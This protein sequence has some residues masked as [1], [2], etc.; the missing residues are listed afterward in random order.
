MTDNNSDPDRPGSPVDE[1]ELHRNDEADDLRAEAQWY[2][3][4]ATDDARRVQEQHDRIVELLRADVASESVEEHLRRRLAA[5]A[6]LVR[7]AHTDVGTL[8]TRLDTLLEELGAERTRQLSSDPT[9]ESLSR[10]VTDNFVH[11]IGLVV[12][13]RPDTVAELDDMSHYLDAIA[14]TLDTETLRTTAKAV[15]AAASEFDDPGAVSEVLEEMI[16]YP[17]DVVQAWS[18]GAVGRVAAEHPETVAPMA[19]DVRELLASEETAVQHNTVEALGVLSEHRPDAVVPAAATLRELLDHEEVAIQHNAARILASLAESHPDAV[20]PAV[21]QLKSLC[22]HD[23][24]A[25]ER[26][27]TGALA[28]LVQQRPEALAER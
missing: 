14:P 16:G 9:L 24:D 15:F 21:E 27:A 10:E 3:Q 26:V 19:G 5:S 2:A 20:L 1:P 13:E 6:A 12:D 8:A 11:T 7:S 28:R 23:E 17:D 22:N 4:A 25:V 18:V